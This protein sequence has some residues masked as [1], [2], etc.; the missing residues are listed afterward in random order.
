MNVRKFF[1][2]FFFDYFINP[3]ALERTKLFL[4]IRFHGNDR[5]AGG[6]GGGVSNCPVNHNRTTAVLQIVLFP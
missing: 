5:I 1:G 6:S 2:V 4:H 3:S